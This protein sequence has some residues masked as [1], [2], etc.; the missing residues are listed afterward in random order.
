MSVF[1]LLE[2]KLTITGKKYRIVFPEGE[3][4]RILRAAAQLAQGRV[5]EP[6]L[7]GDPKRINMILEKEKIIY[8]SPQIIDF[9][10][11]PRLAKLQQEF[12]NAR[13]KQVGNEMVKKLLQN[14]NYFGT[15]MVQI[16]NADGMVSGVAHSTAET[17]RPALQLIHPAAGMKRVSGSFIMERG[18]EKY[19]F[20]DCAINPEPDSATLAEIAYQ[21]VQTA[22][23]VGLDPQVA[24]LSF[25]TKGSAKGAMVERVAQA[26]KLFKQTYPAIPADGELQFDAAFVPEI[27]AKKAPTSVLAGRANIFVFP[28]LQSGN[29]AYKI[30]QRLGGFIAVGPILQGLAKP[31]NDLSRGANSDDIYNVAIL[32]A[33]QSMLG[34]EN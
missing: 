2:K 7:L 33:A 21:S 4:L 13:G 30:A 6:I 27:A 11:Y 12:I 8:S 25:S 14:P 22:Q 5:I 20:A 10:H 24:F 34:E 31:I 26:C 28:E 16:G 29:I 32:T 17:V 23:M 15:M 3:D 9:M 1:E 18:E 19:I